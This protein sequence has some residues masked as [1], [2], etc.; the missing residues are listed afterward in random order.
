MPNDGKSA[1]FPPAILRMLCAPL[2]KLPT[3][4]RAAIAAAAPSLCST[5]YGM[6][7]G[8]GTGTISG[9]FFRA[10]TA[11]VTV[12]TFRALAALMAANFRATFLPT[13]RNGAVM[14]LSAANLAAFTAA[15]D[16][17]KASLV[18]SLTSV[19]TATWAAIW[20]ALIA[21]IFALS[22][23]AFGWAAVGSASRMVARI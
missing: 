13:T 4:F 12:A 10:A 3:G 9:F 22:R 15:M 2:I 18:F 6:L 7:T 23:R 19:A 16:F 5:G 20:G 14:M 21:A 11:L 1:A 8:T 17:Q